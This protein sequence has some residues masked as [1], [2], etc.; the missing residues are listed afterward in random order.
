MGLVLAAL[1]GTQF[2]AE[3]LVPPTID[4]AMI[5]ERP[6]RL[7]M[8]LSGLLVVPLGDSIRRVDALLEACDCR[9]GRVHALDD[10]LESRVG[11]V[12]ALG[13]VLLV[14]HRTLPEA[15]ESGVRVI[16]GVLRHR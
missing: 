16:V 6:N 14:V 15:S 2:L 11:R 3:Q 12:Q 8:S 13:S 7:R 10:G 5:S 4:V 1:K 9:V